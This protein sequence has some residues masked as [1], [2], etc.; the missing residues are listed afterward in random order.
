MMR[1][2]TIYSLVLLA[3]TVGWCARPLPAAE[4]RKRVMQTMEGG[5]NLLKTDAWRGYGA[6]YEREGEVFICR[7][8]ADGGDVTR[9]AAQS[10]VL[11]QTEP[12]PIYAEAESSAMGVDG[13]ADSDYALY[14]DLVYQDGTPLWGQVAAFQTGTHDWERRSVII[15]PEKPVRSVSVYLLFRHH[16]GEAR[17]RAPRLVADQLP[18]QAGYFDGLPVQV[19]QPGVG[20]LQLRDVAA[21]GD[22][23]EGVD[24]A[25]EFGLEVERTGDGD[26]HWWDVT[27]EDRSGRDR[28]ITLVYSLPLSGEGWTW[29]RGPREAEVVAGGREYRNGRAVTA[30]AIPQMSIYPLGAVSRGDQGLGLGLDMDRPAVYRIGASG[31]SGELYIAFDLGLTPERPTARVR[32]C[33][34]GFDPAW[35]FRAALQRYYSLFPEHF[36][37]RAE[38]HGVWMPFAKIS[39]VAG[40]EDFGFQFK[41]GA[42]E[43]AWDDANGITTFRYTEP[44]TWWMA[45]EAEA[46]RSLAAG[47]EHA[48]GLMAKGDR[49]AMA[50]QGSVFH[51]RSGAVVGRALD[52]PWCD[53][54]VWSMNSS[55]AVPGEHTDFGVKWDAG[56]K[57]AYAGRTQFG[58]HAGLDGEYIDSSE[59]YVTA[60]LN[61]RRAHFAGSSVP[62]TFSF[63]DWRPALFRG[64][65]A[66][67][68][69]REIAE[70]V[71][72]MNGLM[73]ANSTPFR[74]CWLAPWLDV[75][76]TEIDWNPG[77]EWRPMSDADLMFRR[78]MC[79]QKPY[80]FLMNTD[81]DRFPYDLTERFMKRAV[82]YGF[83]PGFFSH[84]ASE[85]HYFS[86]PALY[87]RDRP[88]F[89]KYIPICTRLSQAGWMP[90][91]A[92]RPSD[93]RVVVERFGSDLFTVYNPEPEPIAVELVF[94]RAPAAL[95][96][97][98]TDVEIRPV[99]PGVVALQLP[100][101]ALMV[102]EQTQE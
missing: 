13:G 93:E 64:L 80:C 78:A 71:H 28:A 3:M 51:D 97:L 44:M 29:W 8:P 70:D 54:I 9:G 25:L 98:L 83:F 39:A 56:A 5:E 4:V 69:V 46:D 75:M 61:F 67:E 55:P 59:G 30:G 95:R 68:Y 31:A 82:A 89:K 58:A 81:F 41:E 40:W 12:A 52:T 88:L 57:A 2:K 23:V 90:I 96:E 7:N 72:R 86:R 79:A 84:N 18:R 62:L 76:G 74:L 60:E 6:G 22:F 24:G 50:W 34:F 42:N 73:M 11:N 47:V 20:G 92:V 101:D 33:S 26:V 37:G 32:F 63:G 35:G 65:I 15:F 85:G 43:V 94:D 1:G 91:T 102:L 99:R 36:R 27:L 38:R 49:M 100:P 66:Y 53:G 17:F 48:A 45:M 10:L 16:K 77:G 21:G 14:L 87:E 19:L